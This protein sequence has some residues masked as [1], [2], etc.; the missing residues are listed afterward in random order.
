MKIKISQIDFDNLHQYEKALSI[1]TPVSVI[2]GL[3]S[4]L[5]FDTEAKQIKIYLLDV[6][7]MVNISMP[8]CIV[9]IENEERN[10]ETKFGFNIDF[11]KFLYAIEQYKDSK[12]IVLELLIEGEKSSLTIRNNLD[13]ICLPTLKLENYKIEELTTLFINFNWDEN[14]IIF[15]SLT[16]KDFLAELS[17]VFRNSILFINKDEKKNNAGVIYSDKFIVNDRRHIYIQNFKNPLPIEDLNFPIHKK[18]MRIF[19]DTLNTEKNYTLVYKKEENKIFISTDG[20]SGILNNSI[21]NA[22][23]PSLEDL[24]SIRPTIKVFENLASV[25]TPSFLFFS[26]FYTASTEVRPISIKFKPNKNEMGVYLKDSG[27]AGFGQYSVEKILTTNFI[28]E[29]EEELSSTLIYDSIKDFLTKESDN[30]VVEIYMDSEHGAVY[31]KS[32]NQEIY[33]S[34]LLG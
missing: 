28:N 4:S 19:S 32:P 29:L 2:G 6:T 1:L 20:F 25:L 14:D 31:V 5:V 9:D 10:V 22:V 8:C 7:A 15:T 26:G 11:K 12:N 23:P 24:E 18:N 17:L 33:L 27:V 3:N 16:H 34:K 30:S 21:A 13:T